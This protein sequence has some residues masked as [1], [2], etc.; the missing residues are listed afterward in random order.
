MVHGVYARGAL[1]VIWGLRISNPGWKNLISNVMI[2]VDSQIPIQCSYAYA[3][4]FSNSKLIW[5]LKFQ[6][7]V[8]MHMHV[9]SGMP[10]FLRSNVYN[11]LPFTVFTYVSRPSATMLAKL[12]VHWFCATVIAWTAEGI[13]RWLCCNICMVGIH[14]ARFFTLWFYITHSWRI[15]YRPTS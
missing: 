4:W 8:D 5:I 9:H 15:A 12:P 7:N 3:C 14:I 1:R 2:H 6:F 10:N 11:F 13:F